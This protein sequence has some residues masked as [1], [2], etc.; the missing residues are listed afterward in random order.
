MLERCRKLI[1]V[2]KG[3]R[4]KNSYKFSRALWAITVHFKVIYVKPYQDIIRSLNF[5]SLGFTCKFWPKRFHQIDP[6]AIRTSVRTTI[7]STTALTFSWYSFGGQ[8][9]KTLFDDFRRKKLPFK[10]LNVM[11]ILY[12]YV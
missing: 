10:K 3:D 5:N 2:S 7:R 6:S 11:I 12:T 8:C 9:Y 1:P 4:G